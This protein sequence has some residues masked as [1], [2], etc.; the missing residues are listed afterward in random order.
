MSPAKKNLRKLVILGVGPGKFLVHANDS[1]DQ[2]RSGI[3]KLLQRVPFELKKIDSKQAA[4]L[5][6]K[7]SKAQL[8][9]L[10]RLSAKV[11]VTFKTKSEA[12]AFLLVLSQET[13]LAASASEDGNLRFNPVI[14]KVVKPLQGGIG[15]VGVTVGVGIAGKF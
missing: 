1:H 12:S 13:R 2:V 7:L 15:P 10:S 9:L 6:S 8:D 11:S 14:S 3:E 4:A 5:K